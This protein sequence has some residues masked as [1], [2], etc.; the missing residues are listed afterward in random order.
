MGGDHVSV[1]V[2]AESQANQNVTVFDLDDCDVFSI[3]I[4][5]VTLFVKPEAFRVL[6]DRIRNPQ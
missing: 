3:A 2:H 4:G 1:N 6:Q 5:D